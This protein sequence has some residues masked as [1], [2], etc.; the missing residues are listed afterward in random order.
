MRF[1]VSDMVE[2]IDVAYRRAD[3]EL[4]SHPSHHIKSTTV[5]CLLSSYLAAGFVICLKIVSFTLLETR[6]RSAASS[7]PHCQ[8][9]VPRDPEQGTERHSEHST[10]NT[11]DPY[12]TNCSLIDYDCEINVE[13]KKPSLQC[14]AATSFVNTSRKQMLWKSMIVGTLSLLNIWNPSLILPSEN[15][16]P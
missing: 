15:I 6:L 12:S 16:M 8:L 14:H 4:S 10:L 7:T 5:T 3:V 9:R 13:A 2:P 1:E 11:H